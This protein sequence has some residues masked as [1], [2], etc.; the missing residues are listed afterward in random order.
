MA[1]D[2]NAPTEAVSPVKERGIDDVDDRR[3]ETLPRDQVMSLAWSGL[4]S[5]WPLPW[6]LP[7]EAVSPV[8]DREGGDV[9]DRRRETLPRDQVMSL[10]W[11]LPWSLPWSLLWSLPWPLSLRLSVPSRIERWMTWMTGRERHFQE[12]G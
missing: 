12:T 2:W 6:P 3:R 7:T 4:V 1:V 8:K 10:A 9:D 11:S 5:P